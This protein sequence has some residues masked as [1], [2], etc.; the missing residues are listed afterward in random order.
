MANIKKM[1]RNTVIIGLAVAMCF[2]VV[3]VFA[4]SYAMETFDVQAEAL[5]FEEADIY[6][7]PFPDYSIIGLEDNVWGALLVGIAGTLLLFAVSFGVAKLIGKK[8]KKA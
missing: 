1:N 4:L 6:T 5:G 7:A 3:G 2:V 8:G